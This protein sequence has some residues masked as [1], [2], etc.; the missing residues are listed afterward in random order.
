MNNLLK[1]SFKRINKSKNEENR[2]RKEINNLNKYI[3]KRKKKK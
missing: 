1:N 3:K 2:N